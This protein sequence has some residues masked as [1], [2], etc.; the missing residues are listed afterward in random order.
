MTSRRETLLQGA[1]DDLSTRGNQSIA[2]TARNWTVNRTT[3]RNRV[4]RHLSY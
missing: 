3:L 1:S 4:L 2:K